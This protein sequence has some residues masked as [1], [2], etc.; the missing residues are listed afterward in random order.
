MHLPF[1]IKKTPQNSRIAW[2]QI[3]SI[4]KRL[5]FLQS[6]SALVLSTRPLSFIDTNLI[7][8][9]INEPMWNNGFNFRK[10]NNLCRSYMGWDQICVN[11][12]KNS[13]I[14]TYVD[15]SNC[16]LLENRTA[17]VCFHWKCSQAR[18]WLSEH[19]PQILSEAIQLL[20]YIMNSNLNF[21]LKKPPL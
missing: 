4:I 1:V 12:T 10:N 11:S 9:T 2:S 3:S 16:C 5:F 15:I 14:L 13:E 18:S 7:R 8:S 17:W 6:A 19:A 21:T 20:F